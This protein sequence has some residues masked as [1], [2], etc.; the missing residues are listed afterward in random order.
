MK[1]TIRVEIEHCIELIENIVEGDMA[2]FHKPPLDF[3]KN[4]YLVERVYFDGN[5]STFLKKSL[6][7]T[8]NL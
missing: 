3:Q 4:Y 7:N 8:K 2:S 6:V 1:F 5:N